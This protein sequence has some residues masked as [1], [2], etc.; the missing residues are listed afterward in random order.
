[1]A[2]LVLLDTRV[3]PGGATAPAAPSREEL[4]ALLARDLA[5]LS[6]GGDLAMGLD[7]AAA[8]PLLAAFE[9]NLR[10]LRAYRPEPYDGEALLVA[11]E[12]TAGAAGDPDL[13]WRGTISGLRRE[14]VSGGHY[15]LV[16]PPTVGEVARCLDAAA[17]ADA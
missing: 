10:A 11:T 17:A 12:G 4:R 13:G 5:G 2:A 14:P 6:G 16:R 8:A 7:E 3:P 1:V 9:T 15:D